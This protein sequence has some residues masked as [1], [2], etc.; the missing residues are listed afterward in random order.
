M[1]D[2]GK[3]YEELAARGKYAEAI[4]YAKRVIKLA[5]QEFGEAHQYYA[6][7]LN[8]LAELFFTITANLRRNRS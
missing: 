4:P 6:A 7:G 3:H 5:G 2:V 1:V 8:K